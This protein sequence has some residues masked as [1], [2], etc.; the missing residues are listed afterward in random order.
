[1]LDSGE[2]VSSKNYAEKSNPAPEVTRAEVLLK[3]RK[4]KEMTQEMIKKFE[5]AGCKRWTKGN[6]DR[7]YISASTLGLECNYYSTGNIKGAKLAGMEI[8]NCLARKIKA[9]KMYFEVSDGSF[10]SDFVDTKIDMAV[11]DFVAKLV[12]AN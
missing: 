7:L 3:K 2:N 1:M 4:D 5:D 12:E 6:L 10:H 11:A 9:A 8:S